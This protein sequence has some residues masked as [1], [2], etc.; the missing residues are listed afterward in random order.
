MSDQYPIQNLAK[1][2]EKSDQDQ[3]HASKIPDP[4][5]ARTREKC[6]ANARLIFS[7]CSSNAQ[8]IFNERRNGAFPGA[9]VVGS[10]LKAA[11]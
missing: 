5:W 10:V 3:T 4:Q 6:S 9:S 11:G 2:D 7:Q 1:F 8:Q